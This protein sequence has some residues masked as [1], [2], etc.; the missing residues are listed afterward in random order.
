MKYVN[1]CK[2]LFRILRKLS[3][4]TLFASICPLFCN[5][6]SCECQTWCIQLRNGFQ[7]WILMYLGLSLIF[8]FVLFLFLGKYIFQFAFVKKRAFVFS[9]NLPICPLSYLSHMFLWQEFVKMHLSEWFYTFIWC[10]S[11][12]L[13]MIKFYQNK[14]YI[15]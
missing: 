15:L 9:S 5:N 8:F 2:D 6:S 3:L 10:T 4:I 11:W 13:Y 7:V 1:S 14:N 12:A